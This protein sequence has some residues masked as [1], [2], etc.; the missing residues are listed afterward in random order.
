MSNY[1]RPNRFDYL[2]LI[3]VMLVGWWLEQYNG[4]IACQIVVAGGITWFI[5]LPILAP[6]KFNERRP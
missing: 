1:V 3:P 2:M 4:S 5:L 6:D